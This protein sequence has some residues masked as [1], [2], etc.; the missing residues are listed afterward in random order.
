MNR[1][2]EYLSDYIGVIGMLQRLGLVLWLFSIFVVNI[3]SAS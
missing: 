1:T 3:T 2:F